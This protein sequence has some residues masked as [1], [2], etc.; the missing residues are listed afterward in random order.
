MSDYLNDDEQLARLK[1]WWDEN[2][3]ST[4]AGLVIVIVAT[5]G[6]RWYGEHRDESIARAS[7]L[8]EEFLAAEGEQREALAARIGEEAAGSAYETFELMNSARTAMDAADYQAAGEHLERAVD[9]A[10]EP[11]LA[12][13]IRIRLARVQLQ[14]DRSDAAMQT[15]GAVRGEG[16]RSLVAELKGDIHMARGE[17]RL[18]HEAYLAAQ[19]D[20]GERGPRPMLAMKVADTADALSEDVGEAPVDAPGGGSPDTGSEGTTETPEGQNEAVD[21]TEAEGDATEV[22]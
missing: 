19:A 17:R 15:L 3:T 22:P 8:Y 11:V 13:L 10:P 4:I 6:W 14:L 20:A 7:D 9:A 12:D 2:G 16:Y 21:A 5:V 1:S 18:A